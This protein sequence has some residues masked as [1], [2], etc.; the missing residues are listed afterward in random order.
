M[1]P[2]KTE[3]RIKKYKS[4]ED[5]NR[6]L[7]GEKRKKERQIFKMKSQYLGR[8]EDR[9][10]SDFY[11]DYSRVLDADEKYKHMRARLKELNKMLGGD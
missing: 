4:L 3:Y 2:S 6:A 1:F 11:D 9:N 8:E 5:L 10:R 7:K